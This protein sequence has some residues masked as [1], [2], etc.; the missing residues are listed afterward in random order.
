MA[1]AARGSKEQHQ[2]ATPRTR[3]FGYEREGGTEDL[4][5][6]EWEIVRKE[7]LET[8]LMPMDRARPRKYGTA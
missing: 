3:S 5:K 8:M 6:E 7:F 4:Q 2:A 1:F